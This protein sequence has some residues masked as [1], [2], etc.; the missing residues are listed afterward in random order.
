MKLSRVVASLTMALAVLL[1][2]RIANAQPV[3]TDILN[4]PGFGSMASGTLWQIGGSPQPAPI[5]NTALAQINNRLSLSVP[6]LT[7]QR[8]QTGSYSCGA[9]LS[10]VTFIESN[11]GTGIK[12]VGFQGAFNAPWGGVPLT[13]FPDNNLFEAVFFH[14]DPCY[15]V[16]SDGVSSNGSTSREYGFFL[17]GSNSS[18]WVYWGTHENQASVVQAQLQLPGVN[19]NTEYYFEIYPTGNSSSCGFQVTVLNTGFGVVYNHW[20]D[21]NSNNF[22]G[23]ITATDP[24]FCGAITSASGDT[25]Y[26]SANIT[27]GPL[28]SGTLP[29]ASQLSTFMQRVFVGK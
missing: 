18:V 20:L 15:G 13:Y 28:V 17:A 25:G 3:W 11:Q 22:G 12:G 1:V 23:T 2:E 10:P 21:V 16:A 7:G 26:V 9:V 4:Q 6:V 14:E 27:A 5:W 8:N 29:P 24:G 19:P